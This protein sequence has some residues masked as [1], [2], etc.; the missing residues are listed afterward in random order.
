M[1]QKHIRK[2]E[3]SL[4]I[5]MRIFEFKNRYLAKMSFLS[6]NFNTIQHINWLRI[7]YH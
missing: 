3:I 4:E 7:M 5:K 6:K 2:E 1:Q